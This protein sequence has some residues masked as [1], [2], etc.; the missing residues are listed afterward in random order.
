LS[1]EGIRA[2]SVTSKGS[3]VIGE[4]ERGEVDVLVGS[5]THYGVLVRGIDIPWRVKYAVFVGIPK[6]KFRIGEALH[7]LVM[8]KLLSWI[9]VTVKDREIQPIISHLRSKLGHMSQ[10]GLVL[11]WKEIR[12]GKF[13]DRVLERA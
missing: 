4:F 2:A 9:A 5:A 10:T 1:S 11:L 8:L 7:P 12:E 6:F 3:K 13:R